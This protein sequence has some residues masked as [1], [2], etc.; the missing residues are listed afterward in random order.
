M[1]PRE[2][3]KSSG[4]HTFLSANDLLRSKLPRRQVS[5]QAYYRWL[6]NT[7]KLRLLSAL[8]YR[9]RPLDPIVPLTL[10]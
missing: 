9:S 8:N 5:E 1:L 4:K 6:R 7:P 10:V 3:S 2:S